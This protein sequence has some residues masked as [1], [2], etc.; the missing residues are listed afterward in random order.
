MLIVPEEVV[1]QPRLTVSILVLQAEGLLS[2]IRY[3]GFLFQTTL[4]SI[5]AEPQEV[6]EIV[7]VVTCASVGFQVVVLNGRANALFNQFDFQIS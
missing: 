3:L 1:M 6:A 2:A 4:G 5:F 7:V